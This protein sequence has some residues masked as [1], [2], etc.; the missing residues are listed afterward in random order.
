[1]LAV[2]E[3][4]VQDPSVQEVSVQEENSKQQGFGGPESDEWWIDMCIVALAKAAS[5]ALLSWREK[6]L[7]VDCP[8]P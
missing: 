2:S 4:M 8:I 3:L 7:G 1:M 5:W 6:M